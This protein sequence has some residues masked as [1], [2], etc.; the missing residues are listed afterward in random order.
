MQLAANFVQH[1]FQSFVLPR[2]N[3]NPSGRRRRNLQLLGRDLV[4]RVLNDPHRQAD[5][6]RRLTSPSFS[7]LSESWSSL[8]TSI[9]RRL[10][11]SVADASGRCRRSSTPFDIASNSRAPSSPSGTVDNVFSSVSVLP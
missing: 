7:P 11:R 5:R 3:V 9:T 1:F 6:C 4:F 8:T 10:P 2:R